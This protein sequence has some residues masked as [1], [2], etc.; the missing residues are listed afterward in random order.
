M[1]PH[2]LP[3]EE[4]ALYDFHSGAPGP[5]AYAQ[6]LAELIE[7]LNARLA[8]IGADELRLE[9][10]ESPRRT[11]PE[12]P[13]RLI[14][15]YGEALVA[16]AER[17][18][19]LVALDGDLRLD[20]GLVP[21]QERFPE[22]FFECGIAEQDLVSQAGAMALAGLLP[23]C[24]SFACF[25][26]PRAAEQVFNNASEGTKVLYHGSLAG[27][28]PGGPGHSHQSVRDIALMGS[29][30]GLAA[31]EPYCE[32]RGSARGRVGRARGRRPRLSPA[33]LAALAARLRSARRR[34]RRGPRHRPARGRGRNVRLHRPR[35]RLPGVGGVRRARR[36]GPD[37]AAVAARRST[38]P[39]SPSTRRARS[40]ASTT[41]SSPA[42]RARRCSTR[43]PRP[44]RR[45][46]PARASWA[47]TGSPSAA[48][49]TRSCA[50]TGSTR[51]SRGA[52]LSRAPAGLSV[53]AGV[54]AGA[55]IAIVSAPAEALVATAAS[56]GP[57]RS[58]RSA[59]R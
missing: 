23:V 42:A 15:A 59:Q 31:I 2:A 52:C 27:I 30:P 43:S 1:E 55:R 20:T 33:R 3:Q 35:A 44:R 24:H 36:L 37:R 46:P 12:R 26:T 9:T 41:T 18:P 7:R 4:T 22:R 58:S 38:A 13:Q 10:R 39:G 48:R 50:R 11:P 14:H 8:G 49:T 32:S 29:V 54:L 28:V 21:F 56:T 16:A 34:A 45:P 6:A 57:S 51:Q 5:A 53:D 17:E 47:S 25:L 19:S 40:S